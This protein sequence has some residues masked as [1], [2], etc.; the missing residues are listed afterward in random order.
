MRY[1]AQRELIH[2]IIMDTI[3]HPTAD[4]IYDRAREKMPKISLGTVYRNLKQLEDEGMIRSLLE[5]NMTRYDGNIQPHHHLRCNICGD[6]IDVDI[7]DTNLRK[8]IQKD[9][10]FE[11]DEI[12]MV[13]FG[14]CSKH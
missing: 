12:E 14:T 3:S 13:F 6:L 8:G 7:P 5:E 4:W 2:S 10:Q 11:V 9:Y 1:S